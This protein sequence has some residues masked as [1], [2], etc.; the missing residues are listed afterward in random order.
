MRTR[1]WWQQLLQPDTDRA[2][3]MEAIVL[4]VIAIGALA[5][6]WKWS[7]VRLVVVGT[8]LVTAGLFGLRAGH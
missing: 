3:A 6:T 7:S 4:A 1:S 5:W 8:V 2:I